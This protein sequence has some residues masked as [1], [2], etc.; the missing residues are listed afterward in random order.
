MKRSQQIVL[1][2]AGI[3]LVAALWPA[4]ETPPDTAT[5]STSPLVYASAAECKAGGI[6][7]ATDC[8]E[9]WTLAE[10][11]QTAAAPKFDQLGACE[12][13]FGEGSC[14]QATA[15]GGG[16]FFVPAMIGYMLGRQLGGVAGRPIAQPLFPGR[17]QEAGGASA[18]GAARGVSPATRSYTTGAGI[19]VVTNPRGGPSSIARTTT[20]APSSR[21]TV[22]RGGFGS[23]SPGYSSGG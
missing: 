4:S 21:S 6:V 20:S 3:I 16:S 11:Q 22:S 1:G 19:P 23:T 14:R 10:A 18:G 12:T 15:P 7:P 17:P 2:A 9:Q 5:D 8:D 13:N